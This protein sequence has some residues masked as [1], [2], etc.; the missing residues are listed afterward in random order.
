ML[1]RR[2]GRFAI[3][4]A[5]RLADHR[6]HDE[7]HRDDQLIRDEREGLSCAVV[8]DVLIGEVHRGLARRGAGEGDLGR[9]SLENLQVDHQDA[10]QANLVRPNRRHEADPSASSDLLSGHAGLPKADPNQADRHDAGRG[11]CESSDRP[12]RAEPE[13]R[14]GQDADGPERR[15][16]HVQASLLGEPMPAIEAADNR[17]VERI[18]K[19][20]QRCDSHQS[21]ELTVQQEP[22]YRWRECE[23]G[24]G[25]GASDQGLNAQPLS[26]GHLR[27]TLVFTHEFRNRLDR[28]D[29]QHIG[30]NRHPAHRRR[31]ETELLGLAEDPRQQ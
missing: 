23:E 14:S 31:I 29:N 15:E 12:H 6:K 16:R 10:V 13:R 20:D 3:P 28:R 17:G 24:Q 5:R 27:T 30:E 18:G 4:D 26:K 8:T 7:R 21:S 2:P 19:H 22:R 1:N 9:R 11:H 25:E